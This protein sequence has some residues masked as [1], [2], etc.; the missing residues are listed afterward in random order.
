MTVVHQ[1]IYGDKNGSYALLKTS[2]ADI[3]LAKRICNA[4]DLLD[5]PS[6][7]YLIQSVFRGFALDNTYVFIKSFPD[8]DPSVRKG[9]VLSHAL[10]AEINDLNEINNLEELFSY[11][12][13]EPD[14]DPELSCIVIDSESSDSNKII[15]HMSREAAGIN[16]LLDHSSYNNT[17]V[18]VG[19]EGY[20]S[21]VSQVWRQLEGNLRAKLNLGVGFSYQR[22]N[23][24]NHNI[25]YVLEDYESKW[26][27]SGFFIVGKKDLGTLESLASLRLA[28]QKDKSKPLDSLIKKF[29][30]VLEDIEDYGYVETILPTYEELSAKTE[31]NSLIV[32]CD[33]IDKYS[34]S[35]NVAKEEKD[36][37]LKHVISRI[38]LLTAPEILK[39]NNVEWKGFL[40]A[41]KSIGGKIKNWVKLSLL[42]PEIYGSIGS[43][44]A[45]AFA[46]KNNN[47]WWEKSFLSGLKAAFKN[48]KSTYATSLWSWF[49][50]DHNLVIT[51]KDIIPINEQVEIDFVSYWQTPDNELAKNIQKLSKEREWLILHGLSTLQLLNPEES[52]KSQLVIDTDLEHTIALRNM[53][54]SIP[55]KEFIELTIKL[56]EQRLIKIAGEKLS[57]SPPLISRLD[58]KN[59][60]WRQIWL[61]S[62]ELGML[63]YDAIKKP[64][65]V[66][67][68]FLEE[69]VDGAAVESELLL[70]FSKSD[71]NDIS[72]FKLRA[73]VWPRLEDVVKS[74]FI[75]P[76]TLG[77]LRLIDDKSINIGDLEDDIRT[78]LSSVYF[79][80]QVISDQTI[81]VFTKI[82]LFNEL[83]VLKE[84]E[85]LMLLDVVIFLPD[86]SKELGELIFR[87]NWK[88][89]ASAISNKI[90]SR[91]DLR[92]ALKECS[93]LL[94]YF[95]RLRLSF[96][97]HSSETV[98]A[99]EWWSAFSEQCYTKYPKGPTDK[100]LWGRAGGENYDLYISGTGREV[101][102]D[103]ISK[104]RSKRTDVIALKLLQEMLKDYSN[105]TELK[106]LRKAYL[107]NEK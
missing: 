29:G 40:N 91:N 103:I 32:L 102:V 106:Q 107:S 30:I 98:S 57:R 54:E 35:Q 13:T 20:I 64:E 104:I 74:G 79:I 63:P 60:I 82:L 26:K 86:E 36:K 85:L 44:V 77:C 46:S 2:L 56:G 92:L 105:S 17:L 14:K 89:A 8:S 62:I 16:G 39:L 67:F 71:F 7:G 93:L 66:L 43:L 96:S 11:F 15:S 81:S 78:H 84:N 97:G 50:T 24:Q 9:R 37:L 80:R 41:H 65:E 49:L 33:L 100:G 55:D 70:M 61:E 3:E 75:A 27:S 59:I 76:T 22:V 5:R 87:K 19:E 48:W 83:T 58:V 10:I 21:F 38:D 73:K 25:L 90:S 45:A 51:L 31:F 4:T 18:W 28:G 42:K 72:S 23:T 52:I 6:N 1:A 12:L 94:G 68:E 47:G 95:E 88:K 101:W 34:P 99:E 69:V 53:G